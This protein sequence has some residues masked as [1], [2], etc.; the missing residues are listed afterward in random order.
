MSP[1]VVNSGFKIE[2]SH[3]SFNMMTIIGDQRGGGGV[4][5]S[6]L[7][8]VEL[9]LADD[10]FV[11]KAEFNGKSIGKGGGGDALFLTVVPQLDLDFSGREGFVGECTKVNDGFMFMVWGEEGGGRESE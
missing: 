5:D 2:L 11:M 7:L 9:P 10:F 8:K 3:E 6:I 4:R 1:V